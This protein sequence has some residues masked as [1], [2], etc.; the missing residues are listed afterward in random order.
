MKF[1]VYMIWKLWNA[2]SVEQTISN[3]SVLEEAIWK[4]S[5]QEETVSDLEVARNNLYVLDNLYLL[6]EGNMYQLHSRLL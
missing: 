5:V 4:I 3:I 6:L 1:P 2:T